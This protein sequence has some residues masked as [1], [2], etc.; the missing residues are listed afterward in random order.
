MYYLGY[1]GVVNYK[2]IRIGGISGIHKEYNYYRGH[3]EYS[4]YNSNSMRSVYHYRQQDVTRL[5]QISEPIDIMMSHD[6]PNEVANYGNAEDLCQRKP[7]FRIQIDENVLGSPPCLELLRQLKPSYWFSGHLHCKFEAVIPHQDGKDTKFMSGGK[8][9]PDPT[10]SFVQ[11]VEVNKKN[12]SQEL[13][14][15][16]EWLTI[17][18]VTK[19][20][21]SVNPYPSRMSDMRHLHIRSNFVPSSNEIFNRFHKNLVIPKNFEVTAE[22]Y[23][24]SEPNLQPQQPKPTLNPQTTLLCNLLDIDD[25]LSLVLRARGKTFE[26][27]RMNSTENLKSQET[28]AVDNK[29]KNATDAVPTPIKRVSLLA[30]A[31]ERALLDCDR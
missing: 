21:M 13:E 15:D 11:F 12:P 22:V 17:L 14:Y 7:H 24:P 4:P 27:F 28:N 6:W 1:A 25:P 3:F 20:S 5:K 2:G 10:H 31:L 18:H 23:N 8:W 26:I 29:S 30:S 9:Q 19:H 16:L